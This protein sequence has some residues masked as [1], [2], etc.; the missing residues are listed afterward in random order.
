MARETFT[1][2]VDLDPILG[3]FHTKED[4]KRILQSILDQRIPHY[5]PIVRIAQED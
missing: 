4:A 2:D 3:A 5:K 1:V